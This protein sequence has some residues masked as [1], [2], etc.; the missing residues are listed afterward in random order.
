MLGTLVV[1]L[2]A[3]PASAILGP[4]NV[5]SS[6]TL[7][8]AL[9]NSSCTTINIAQG[10]Y[11]GNFVPSGSIRNINVVGA[12]ENTTIL[13][14]GGS[15]TVFSNVGDYTVTLS[16]LTITNGSNPSSNCYGA[17]G[18]YIVDPTT[19]SQVNV[20]GNKDSAACGDSAGGILNDENLGGLII[21]NNSSVT[22]NTGSGADCNGGIYNTI[23][24]VLTISGN[25][26][27]SLNSCTG[28]NGT[29]GIGN[30]ACST[31]LMY[32]SSV[33]SN[34][35]PDEGNGGGIWSDGYLYMSGVSI[36][37]NV[38]GSSGEGGDGGGLFV[39]TEYATCPKDGVTTIVAGLIADNQAFDPPS[40][41]G[42]GGGIFVNDGATLNMNGSG[43]VDNNWAANCGG[44]IY[45]VDGG[46]G[47]LNG[48]TVQSNQA[49]ESDGGGG[50]YDEDYG[51]NID[52]NAV[53][54]HNKADGSSNSQEVFG[55]E[56]CGGK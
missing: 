33:T 23:D 18:L 3:S 25:S 29:G 21:T 45:V 5:P 55:G 24:S 8:S 22:R 41:Q 26:V 17:G 12:A 19:L 40:E 16:K 28:I 20:T 54:S 47:T 2:G 46:G 38:A 1:A 36:T 7:A 10:T 48:T 27:V 11:T 15:G 51:L 4:C 35:A 43:G 39:T 53:V 50:T 49:G 14:G 52:S 31:L 6:Y 37:G 9:S 42:D 34:S 13:N 30:D 44:G 32:Q 56:S